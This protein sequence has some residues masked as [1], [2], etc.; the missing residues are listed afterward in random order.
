MGVR[1]SWAAAA[2]VV[3]WACGVWGCGAERP[4]PAPAQPPGARPSAPAAEAPDAGTPQEAP[5]AGGPDAGGP[6]EEQAP[7]AGPVGN[8]GPWPT[9]AL[10][11]YSAAYALG[12]G[13]QSVGVDQGYNLWLL[14]GDEIGVLRPGD[15][16]PT[17]T[18]GVGQASRGFGVGRELAVGSTVICGGTAGRAYVG[19]KATHLEYACEGKQ[20]TW[21]AAPGEECFDPVRWEEFQKGDMDAVQLGEDGR[22][23]LEEHLWRSVGPS[24]GKVPMG[25]R[26]TNDFHYDE[27]RTVV[28]CTRVMRGPLA[29]D[30]FIGTNHGVTRIQGLVY[31]SHRH[32]G[33]Y[34]YKPGVEP[35]PWNGSL[36]ADGDHAVA[37]GQNGDVLIA[38]RYMVGA[39][40]PSA[41]LKDWD[42]EQTFEGAS[43]WRFKTFNRQLSTLEVEDEWRAIAQTTDGAYWVGSKLYGLW[44]TERPVRTTAV[45]TR[46]TQLP[47]EHVSALAATDDGALYVGTDGQGLWRL[48]ADGTTLAQV[49]GVTG[50]R[51][52]QLVYD[53][54]RTPS[55]LHVLTDAGLTVL[56][57]P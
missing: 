12:P 1:G 54:T 27:D 22:V 6:A 42:R 43:P 36:M 3:A 25:I 23:S 5:D 40:V 9:D 33:W 4:G 55:M 16:K 49:P 50:R 52:L 46:V 13:V 32:P 48:E 37:I 15:A 38:N 10:K 56:R 35:T 28:S 57:G 11:D 14:R 51:V 20:R 34:Y 19:Y 31:N 7:D 39:I 21:I 53:P 30:L 24:G 29:G 26:N 2:V 8:P 45:Y 17:W 47:S 41:P 44:R 18:R